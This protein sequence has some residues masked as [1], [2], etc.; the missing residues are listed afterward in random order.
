MRAFS[1]SSV[2]SRAATLLLAA[3]M[4]AACSADPADPEETPPPDGGEQPMLG[5]CE[6]VAD[7]PAEWIAIEG[8]VLDLVNQQRSQGADCGIQGLFGPAEPLAQNAVLDCVARAHSLDMFERDFFDHTNPDG[9]QPSDRMVEAGYPYTRAGENIAGG[10][11]TADG[12]MEQWM[13]S[14]GHCRNIMNPDF[15]DIGI[16]FHRDSLLWTLLVGTR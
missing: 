14:D 7:W 9:E 4:L 3:G 13:E 10:S 11:R 6:A 16:G 5:D 2:R 1:I 15:A 8:Q 12:V